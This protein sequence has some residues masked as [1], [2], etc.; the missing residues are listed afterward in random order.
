MNTKKLFSG[1]LIAAMATVFAS[2]THAAVIADWRFEYDIANPDAFYA[3][4]SGNGH[5]LQQTTGLAAALPDNSTLPSDAE[6]N[7]CAYFSGGMGLQTAAMLDLGAY[8][9]IKVSFWMHNDLPDGVRYIMGSGTNFV[10]VASG[11]AITTNEAGPGQGKAFL[12]TGG[13]VRV[14]SFLHNNPLTQWGGTWEFYEIEYNL[15]AATDSEVIKIFRNGAIVGSD[16]SSAGVLFPAMFNETLYLGGPG[17]VPFVGRLDNVKIESISTPAAIDGWSINTSAA[18]NPLQF[19]YNGQILN[20]LQNLGPVFVGGIGPGAYS[21]SVQSVSQVDGYTVLNCVTSGPI[22]TTYTMKFKKLPDGAMEL[23]VS[24]N[25]NQIEQFRC[26]NIQGNSES[27]KQF[28][29]GEREIEAQGN[30]DGWFASIY[31]PSTGLYFHADWD[32]DWTNGYMNTH[33]LPPRQNFLASHP[34]ISCDSKYGARSDGTRAALKERYVIRAST[35]MWDA[36][37]PVVNNPSEFR[38]ELAEMVF[39]DQRGSGFAIGNFA[40]NWLK[41]ATAGRIKFYSIMQAWADQTGWDQSNPDAYRIPDH[42]TPGPQ[43]GTKAQ[44]RKFIEL[45]KSMGRVGLRCNYLWIGPNSW[46]MLDGSAKRAI[47]STLS[48][49]PFT[50]IYSVKTNLVQ[51]QETDIA[52]DFATTAVYHD[53]WGTAASAGGLVNFDA[54]VPGAA[55]LSATRQYIRDICKIAK[56]THNGPMGT[57]GMLSEFL[58]GEYADTGDFQLYSVFAGA[59]DGGYRYDFTPEYKLHRLHQLT[60]MHSAG[61]GSWFFYGPWVTN[62]SEMGWSSYFGD[63]DKLDAYRSCEVLYGNGGYIGFTDYVSSTCPG[64]RKVHA[65]TECFTVGVVQQYYALQPIDYI[66]YNKNGD[67]QWKTLDQIIPTSNSLAEMQAWYK[68]FHIRYTNGCHVWVNRDASSL[69][70]TTM[71]GRQFTLPQNGWLVYTEDGNVTAYTALTVASPQARVDFCEDKNRGIKYANPRKAPSYMGVS[72]PTVWIDD[73]VHFTLKDPNETFFNAFNERC[74]GQDAVYLE[75]DVTGTS[76]DSD[77]QVDLLDMGL[78]AQQWLSCTDPVNQACEKPWGSSYPLMTVL[79]DNFNASSK[80]TNDQN[81]DLAIRQT[82]VIAQSSWQDI[83]MANTQTGGDYDDHVK[84]NSAGQM[85]LYVDGLPNY[86]SQS[87]VIIV[88]QK[89]LPQSNT[90]KVSWEMGCSEGWIMVWLNTNDTGLDKLDCGFMLKDNGDAIFYDNN[91][92]GIYVALGQIGRG[93]NGLHRFDVT[94]INGQMT[95]NFDSGFAT[96]TYDLSNMGTGRNGIGTFGIYAAGGSSS[97]GTSYFDNFLYRIPVPS[98]CGV[99]GTLYKATDITGPN[100]VPDCYVNVYDFALLALQWL[101]CTDA[102]RPAQCD[103]FW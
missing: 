39:F 5:T 72:L 92:W 20:V 94:V 76:G 68:R 25:A 51:R 84:I 61:I 35:N 74:G 44:L 78:L 2:S 49:A 15:D 42:N 59:A 54:S 24:G 81:A 45:G 41:D 67:T 14:D 88:G 60:T 19:T 36:M 7:Y 22:S 37:G 93:E 4:S 8:R 34:P 30:Q 18:T 97:I 85:Q 103:L 58:I 27:F 87:N 47:D 50:D 75:A 1:V 57:E 102:T 10:A 43:Y 13:Y 29:T 40:L 64:I 53:Q 71:D 46:S 55:T 86:L 9:H 11:I 99:S 23:L 90:Y 101:E 31:W 70:V 6:S 96:R 66:K 73:A 48:L 69:V 98:S 100:G 26:G 12:T 62:W 65:L 77:C 3:D 38:H 17:P 33:R 89:K 28:Y 21:V 56:T 91:Q 79:S 95:V 83:G 16:V 32:P 80:P 63:D 52:T 82:G